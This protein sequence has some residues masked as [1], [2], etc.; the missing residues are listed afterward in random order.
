MSDREMACNGPALVVS[1]RH[2]FRSTRKR[3][4]RARAQRPPAA[5]GSSLVAVWALGRHFSQQ[6]SNTIKP[7]KSE[8]FWL[9]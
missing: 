6:Q 5:E 1:K 9:R 3:A 2:D 8:L 4:F 7:E